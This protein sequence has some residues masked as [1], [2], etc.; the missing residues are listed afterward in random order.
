MNHFVSFSGGKD[1]TAMLLRILEEGWPV[2]EIIFSDTGLEF[3]EMYEHIER[4]EDYIGRKITRIYPEHSFEEIMFDYVY[5]KGPRKGQKGRGWPSFRI[6]WCTG[7]L[8][9]DPIRAYLTKY[10][11]RNKTRAQYI[12]FAADETDRVSLD[13]TGNKRYPLIGWGMTG[14]DTLK[15]C[16]DRG[17]DWGGLYEYFDRVSCWCCPLQSIHCLRMLHRHFPHLWEELREMDARARNKIKPN[18]SLTELETRFRGEMEIL[19]R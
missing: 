9:T 18:Y 2:T 15:F 13:T 19:R 4:V 17:F 16:Y 7:Y 8:K 11:I 6:R 12:G 14:E 5:L 3:P 1:S 10:P